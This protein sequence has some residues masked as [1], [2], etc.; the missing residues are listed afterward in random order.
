MSLRASSRNSRW[1]LIY[2][3]GGVTNRPVRYFYNSAVRQRT[4]RTTACR[5]AVGVYRDGLM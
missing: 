3:G 2:A 4:D 5:S 1:E